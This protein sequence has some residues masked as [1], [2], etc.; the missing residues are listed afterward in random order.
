M[1]KSFLAAIFMLISFIASALQ[2]VMPDQAADLERKAAYELA[3]HLR[4]ASGGEYSVVKESAAKKAPA[5]YV[6]KTAF[7][8]KNNITTAVPQGWII[9]NAGENLVISGGDGQGIFFAVCE[10]LDRLGFRWLDE[11]NTIIPNLKN[12][13]IPQM[14]IT[15]KPHFQ[16]R[17]IYDTLDWY[18][19]SQIFK[20][21]NRGQGY[22]NSTPLDYP[23]IGSPDQHHTF[24]RYSARFP[25]NKPEL[26]S[27][28]P[29]GERIT[30][31]RGQICMTNPEARKL[32]VKILKEF[33]EAD[34]KK[35]AKRGVPAPLIYDISA[36]DNPNP[37]F[38]PTCRELV[39][40]EGTQSAPL[41]QFINYIAE[42]A[43]KR[44]ISKSIAI[45]RYKHDSNVYNIKSYR[46][47]KIQ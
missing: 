30:D 10:F 43:E 38:C 7:S 12:F 37:C 42:E 24:N 31:T 29:Q 34:R 45:S 33:V 14:N 16:I 15:G 11:K 17:Q 36:N 41:I 13:A 25:K 39:K 27:M 19:A 40:Q 47:A 9:K 21:R 5:I 3:I 2:I 20:L 4:M 26:F 28:N 35:A 22:T 6:G 46:S 1:K 44:G 18:T 32:M 8:S 23:L